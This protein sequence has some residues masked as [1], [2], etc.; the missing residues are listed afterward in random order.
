[1][2][3]KGHVFHQ[4]CF[5]STTNIFLLLQVL[6]YFQRFFISNFCLLLTF[7]FLLLFS[8]VFF[9]FQL[10]SLSTDTTDMY[11]VGLWLARCYGVEVVR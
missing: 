11:Y 4:Y 3:L 1:M 5:T 10:F 8:A 2:A 9:Y 6:F 7:F